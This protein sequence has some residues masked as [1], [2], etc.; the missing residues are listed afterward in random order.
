MTEGKEEKLR[1]KTRILVAPLDWGLGH[2]TRCVP[3]IKELIANN[4]DVW[5]AGRG[6]QETLLRAE[7]PDLPFLPLPGYDIE[8]SKTLRGFLWKLISQTPRIISSINAE[9]KWLDRMI[10]VHEFDVVVSDNRFGLYHSNLPSVF[11]THQLSIKS[12][13]GK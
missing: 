6:V 11:V 1:R 2:A 5:L 3:I 8:Y 13:L 9:H 7:F 4:C 10:K 12:P